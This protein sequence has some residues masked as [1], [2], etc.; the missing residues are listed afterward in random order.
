[1]MVVDLVDAPWL[2]WQRKGSP[3][4][5]DDLIGRLCV[6]AGIIMEDASMGAVSLGVGQR[7]RVADIVRAS[8]VIGA[9]A[10][11]AELLEVYL[12]RSI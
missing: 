10:S 5:V 7:E 1:M 9:L 8:E 6:M 3:M 2:V 12:N 4:D 11:A